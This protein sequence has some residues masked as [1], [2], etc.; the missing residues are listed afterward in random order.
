MSLK[1]SQKKRN[2]E[3]HFLSKC[4]ISVKKQVPLSDRMKQSNSFPD[5]MCCRIVL[6]TVELVIAEVCICC[7]FYITAGITFIL[8]PWIYFRRDTYTHTHTYSG[9][10]C[11]IVS[12]LNTW[13]NL[14]GLS[15][16][17]YSFTLTFSENVQLYSHLY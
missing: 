13:D 6:L 11:I 3:K 15:N 5:I 7:L 1:N 10:G 12:R 14:C 9:W 17:K 4:K 2:Q 8:I 16:I